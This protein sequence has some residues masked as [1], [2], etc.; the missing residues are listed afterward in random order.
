MTD[1]MAEDAA[2]P[3][4]EAPDCAAASSGDEVSPFDLERLDLVAVGHVDHGKSTVIGRLM[5]DTGALP[6]GKLEQVKQLCK[7]NARPF[8]YAFLLDALKNEQAQDITIDTARCFFTTPRRHYIIHDAPGHMEF[9]KNMITGASRAQAAL[10]VIDANE[11]V[12]ENSR[13]HGYILSMLGIRQISVL[14]NKMDLLGWEQGA[15][16]A[17]VAEYADF[18]ARLGVHP[19]SFIPV[20]ARDGDNIVARSAAAT[21]YDGPTV[22]D[23]V[24]AFEHL[25]DDLDRPFRMPLQDVYRFTEAGDDRRIFVG[26]IETGRIRP[27]DDILFLPSRKQSTVK[28]IE[29]LSGP[30]PDEAFA[31]QATGLTLDTQV[32]AKPG[33]LMVRADEPE[34]LVATRIRA[35]VFWM[36]SAPLRKGRRYVLRMGAARVA[37]ELEDVISVLDEQELESVAGGGQV[38]R[39]EVAEVILRAVRPVAFDA[40]GVLEPTSRFVIVHG[41]DTAGCGIALEALEDKGRGDV[42][43]RKFLR[44]D[45]SDAE[46]AARYGHAGKA[47]VFVSQSGEAAH[48]LASRVERRLFSRGLHSFYLG[49]ADLGDDK[50]ILARED[51]LGR[52][53]EIAWAMTDAGSIFVASLGDVDRFDLDRLR[54]LTVPHQVVVVDMDAGGD[55]G[56]DIEFP[57]GPDDEAAEAA[58]RA[59]AA[60]GVLP[61]AA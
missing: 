36:N 49:A 25:E 37:A 54:R 40:A 33:E 9:L 16:A 20:S 42:V 38:E 24:E 23:Q 28:T 18:L 39:H 11:G 12:R 56:A 34:P 47:V 26:T 21:W 44:G 27:G 45:V 19:M 2:D 30:W 58:L 3:A 51:H 43:G 5:A 4:L 22:L 31:G 48:A 35:N 7:Q 61:P 52:L 60:A 41:W 59:L 14:V 55:L 17:I 57:P 8:E 13:R 10:L 29:A 50:D 32:Y 6:D 53:G 46:R 15:F 1:R